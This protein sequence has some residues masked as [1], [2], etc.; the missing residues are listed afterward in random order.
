[1]RNVKE[2]TG[3]TPEALLNQPKLTQYEAY[4]FK[5]FNELTGSRTGGEGVRPIPVSE[6]KDYFETWHIN[7]LDERDTMTK[8]LKALDNAYIE[9]SNEKMEAERKKASRG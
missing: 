9:H 8:Y 3:V 1:M 7:S 6:I 2:E 4:H 5:A